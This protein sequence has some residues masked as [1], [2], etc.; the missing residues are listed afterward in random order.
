MSYM[1]KSSFTIFVVFEKN[2]ENW[3]TIMTTIGDSPQFPID[4]FLT[5]VHCMDVLVLYSVRSSRVYVRVQRGAF[6]LCVTLNARLCKK[7]PC[8]VLSQ[9]CP[10]SIKV[11]C[12]TVPVYLYGCS[13]N[14]KHQKII[15]IYSLFGW[16]CILQ[17]S[18]TLFTHG[19][20]LEILIFFFNFHVFLLTF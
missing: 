17:N 15:K 1:K 5:F 18:I 16:F 7:R 11:S 20:I 9:H 8:I 12:P 4:F 19:F 14:S 6:I 13:R 10:S 3:Q 2:V